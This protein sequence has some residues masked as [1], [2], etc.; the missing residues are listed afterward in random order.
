MTQE[1]Q[2]YYKQLRQ[3]DYVINPF[4]TKMMN[5]NDAKKDLPLLLPHGPN[6][7]KLKFNALKRNTDIDLDEW[8]SNYVN[9]NTYVTNKNLKEKQAKS[10]STINKNR[11]SAE[12]LRNTLDKDIKQNDKVLFS[13][14]KTLEKLKKHLVNNKI[15][16]NKLLHSAN[17]SG[18][19]KKDKENQYTESTVRLILQILGI[20]IAGG[21]VYKV[22]NS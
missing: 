20:V 18:Q 4:N 15:E 11:H 16:Y 21:F 14:I 13:R 3:K 2:D 22:S 8:K 12:G 5:P 7:Y 1:L 19:F 10:H 6:A 9:Y 17:A